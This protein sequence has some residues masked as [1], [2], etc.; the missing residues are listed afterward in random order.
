MKQR[1]LYTKISVVLVKMKVKRKRLMRETIFP[2]TCPNGPVQHLMVISVLQISTVEPK[3][4]KVAEI[5]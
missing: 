4:M 1:F 3:A 2:K 5:N